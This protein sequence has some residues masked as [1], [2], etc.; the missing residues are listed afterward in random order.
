MNVSDG[1]RRRLLG[2]VLPVLVLAGCGDGASCLDLAREYQAAMPD[3]MVCDPTEVGSCDAGRP[4]IVSKQDAG[5]KVT[6]EGLC[7]CLGAVNPERTARLDA[8]LARYDGA[9]CTRLACFCPPPELHAA[10]C[11][12]AGKCTGI[13]SL[14]E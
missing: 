2:C 4:L 11:T 6:L 14:G 1:A 5:G 9:G 13:W 10:S 3:A 12:S 7:Q 8:L